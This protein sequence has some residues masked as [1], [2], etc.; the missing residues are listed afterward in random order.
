MHVSAAVGDDVWGEHR[1]MMC[2]RLHER[3]SCF[4]RDEHADSDLVLA[5]TVCS[6]T[7]M[8]VR[9]EQ[10]HHCCVIVS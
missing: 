2:S 4:V 1:K 3:H 5:D 6:A 9:R 8:H 7:T 10:L